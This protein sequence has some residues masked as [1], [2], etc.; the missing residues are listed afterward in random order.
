[1]TF[2]GIKSTKKFSGS[3]ETAIRA[4]YLLSPVLGYVKHRKSF[5]IVCIR[6][7]RTR[8]GLKETKNNNS[9]GYVNQPNP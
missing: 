7:Q 2:L 8:D 3:T 5:G 6:N 9:A 1:M 4:N